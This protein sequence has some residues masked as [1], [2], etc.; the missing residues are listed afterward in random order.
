MIDSHRGKQTHGQLWRRLT[1]HLG[2]FR[3]ELN[4][5]HRDEAQ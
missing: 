4:R 1:F 3:K 5:Y 2:I